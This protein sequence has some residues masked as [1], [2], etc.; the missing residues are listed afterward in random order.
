MQQFQINEPVDI[1][2]GG[3]VVSYGT[4]VA[5]PFTYTQ[6][7][8]GDV[9]EAYHIKDHEGKIYARDVSA[10]Q[11]MPREK[12]LIYITGEQACKDE[13]NKRNVSLANRIRELKEE[14][15]VCNG[16]NE[17]V[18]LQE[19]S[20]NAYSSEVS[21]LRQLIVDIRKSLKDGD[22]DLALTLAD[23]TLVPYM[24]ERISW[25]VY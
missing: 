25:L 24:D 10:L 9:R 19:E 21:D 16:L 15:E 7:E 18:K 4:I 1:L 23:H 13:S 14:V 6:N 2:K 17:R 3:K 20:L 11:A 5:G 8:T 22:P 12:L